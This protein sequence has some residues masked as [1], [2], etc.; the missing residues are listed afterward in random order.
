MF[1]K[2]VSSVLF[3]SSGFYVF[4]KGTS[5]LLFGILKNCVTKMIDCI[6]KIDFL[7]LC[8]EHFVVVVILVVTKCIHFNSLCN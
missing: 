1:F 3:S 8:T 7:I 6:L 4:V 2:P 5:V